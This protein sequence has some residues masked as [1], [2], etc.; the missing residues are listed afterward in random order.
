LKGGINMNKGLIYSVALIAV[1]LSLSV[2]F[3]SAE[4]GGNDSGSDIE[5]DEDLN[6]TEFE[7]DNEVEIEKDQ[8]RNK[9]KLK[10]NRTDAESELEIEIKNEGNKSKI[11][12]KLSNGRNAEIKIM[13]DSAS[14]R[15]LER[16]GLKVCNESNNC[17][18]QLKET[19][20]G[21]ETRASYEMQAERHFKLLGLF[22][23][24]A[25]VRAEVDAESGNVTATHGP[26]WSF[27]ASEPAE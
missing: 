18:I 17:T 3:V 11:K 10:D 19:G 21:N 27:L 1:M 7:D 13:P 5:D 20:K 26:W 12:V 23:M 2:A 25:Q 15:A 16:L 4:N 22:S 8:E 9:T 24:K 6:E 14:L